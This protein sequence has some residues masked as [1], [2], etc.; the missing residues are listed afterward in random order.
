MED[1]K[2]AASLG[3][4][5]GASQR[6]LYRMR[7]AIICHEVPFQNSSPRTWTVMPLE[8]VTRLSVA[9]VLV[10]CTTVWPEITRRAESA[11]RL[12]SNVLAAALA[13]VPDTP[14]CCRLILSGVMAPLAGGT[15]ASVSTSIRWP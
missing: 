3:C 11:A 13:T 14:C 9:E 2:K 12:R 4:G 10:T 6:F 1:E 7:R 5:Q 15:A 8:T